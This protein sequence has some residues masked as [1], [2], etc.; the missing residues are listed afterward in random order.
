MKTKQNFTLLELLIVVAI[1]AILAGLLLPALSKARDKAMSIQCTS[2]FKQFGTAFGMYAADYGDYYPIV[3]M[4]ST[5][6]YWAFQLGKYCGVNIGVD[7]PSQ[8]NTTIASI[9][10]K[11]LYHPAYSTGIFKC[12]RWDKANFISAY[13]S[14]ASYYYGP[15]GYAWNHYHISDTTKGALT[16]ISK[17]RDAT[18]R[19][20]GGDSKDVDLEFTPTAYWEYKTFKVQDSTAL[21]PKELSA[22]HG[23]SGNYLMLDGH[24]QIFQPQKL[25]TERLVNHLHYRW[26]WPYFAG[27]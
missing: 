20:V 27:R 4:G 1:I 19:I 26:D 10:Q 12:P 18:K 23:G 3:Q 7:M 25:A 11:A 5:S 21:N 15:F 24:T 2:N 6:G 9:G 17:I 22:R 13:P 14:S 16:K 8:M